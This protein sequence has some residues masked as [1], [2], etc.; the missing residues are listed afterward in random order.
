MG[1][2]TKALI[3]GAGAIG[4]TLGAYLAQA[5]HDVTLV[6]TVADHV[7]AINRDGLRI[8]DPIAEFTAHVPAFTPDQVSGEW[9]TIILTTKAQHTAKARVFSAP[10]AFRFH[11]KE[12]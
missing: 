6:D 2:F 10:S 7:A 5:G 1:G 12:Q 4:G 8:T 3:W 9:E 11:Y